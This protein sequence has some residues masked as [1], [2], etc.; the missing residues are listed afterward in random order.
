MSKINLK[1]L[2]YKPVI[3][4]QRALVEY[5]KANGEFMTCDVMQGYGQTTT[6]KE[7]KALGITHAQIRYGVADRKVWYGEL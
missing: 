2:G 5:I 6:P 4:S 7:L 3:N 1:P